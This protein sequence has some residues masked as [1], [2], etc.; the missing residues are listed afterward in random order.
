MK[1]TRLKQFLSLMLSICMIFTAFTPIQINAATA[2]G[3]MEIGESGS[4]KA[5]IPKPFNQNHD[6]VHA[7]YLKTGDN[8]YHITYCAGFNDSLHSADSLSKTTSPKN[9]TTNKISDKNQARIALIVKNGL[10]GEYKSEAKVKSA[11]NSHKKK[12]VATQIA[13]WVVAH[14]YYSKKTKWSK[15]INHL[16]SDTTIRTQA[17]DLLKSIAKEELVVSYSKKNDPKTYGMTLN[18]NEKFKKTLTD[19]N[20]AYSNTTFKSSNSKFTIKKSGKKITITAPKSVKGKT[21]TI[22]CTKTLNNS[23]PVFYQGTNTQALSIVNGKTTITS[24]FKVSA[25]AEEPPVTTTEECGLVVTKQSNDGVVS[26]ITFTLYDENENVIRTGSTNSNGKIEWLDLEPGTYI[27]REENKEGEVAGLNPDNYVLFPETKVTL[28]TKKN[29]AINYSYVTAKNTRCKFRAKIKKKIVQSTYG[30]VISPKGAVFGLYSCNS[31]FDGDFYTSLDE[32]QIAELKDSDI[33]LVQG[34]TIG[35]DGTGISNSINYDSAKTYFV[36]EITPPPG[37]DL[38]NEIQVLYIENN[39]NDPE[40]EYDAEDDTIQLDGSEN[41]VVAEFEFTNKQ[42]MKKFA[43]QK[44]DKETN[45]PVCLE[46]FKF[47]ILDKDKNV[48]SL[49]VEDENAESKD[50]EVDTVGTDSD[51]SDEIEGVLQDTFVTNED[52]VIQFTQGLPYGTYYVKELDAPS[53]YLVNSELKELVI[54]ENFKSD[55][56]DKNKY[57]GESDNDDGCVQEFDD[58]EDPFEIDEEDKED[59]DYVENYVVTYKNERQKGKIKIFKY[60]NMFTTVLEKDGC[61]T[62]SYS[63]D[64]LKGAKFNVYK[65]DGIDED[66]KPVGVITIGDD[67]IGTLDNLELGNYVIEEIKAPDGYNIKVNEE[68]DEDEIN[69]TI[70]NEV[71]AEGNKIKDDSDDEGLIY[72]TLEY[73]KEKE[74][75]IAKTSK[76]NETTTLG[77]YVSKEFE[78]DNGKYED[79]TFGLFANQKFEATDGKTINKDDLITKIKIDED[80]NGYYVAQVPYGKYYVKEISTSDGYQLDNTHYEFIFEYTGVDREDIEINEGE[81]IINYPIDEEVIYPEDTDGPEEKKVVLTTPETE[82]KKKK[83]TEKVAAVPVK[84]G[85]ETPVTPLLFVLII[86]IVGLVS[87]LSCR[88]IKIKK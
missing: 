57:W 19:T 64:Y 21:A 35:E 14:G 39:T 77:I 40:Y 82:K 8:S 29:V 22:T 18:S 58:Y 20:G 56:Y 86:S 47:Q 51:T 61:K 67:G 42:T 69:S 24:K 34:I 32:E 6:N 9:Q 53:P 80:G 16:T 23:K 30:N 41:G 38:S 55:N 25:K 2:G 1:K 27:L 70:K 83:K 12:Y 74:S 37:C 65:G 31:E 15:I 66:S 5:S 78:D 49:Y 3:F 7:L 76:E 88:K 72:V 11:I 84:T 26:G 52:G 81:P 45:T 10:N 33:T 73:D 17:K 48:I 50:K 71:D 68:E 28:S 4:A 87:T 62:P 79:V 75:V 59:E 85:D 13:V 63:Y 36:K 43:I 60:G 54:D 44:V 46:G